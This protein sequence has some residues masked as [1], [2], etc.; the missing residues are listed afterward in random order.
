MGS[1]RAS[2]YDLAIEA[3]SLLTNLR[4]A[5]EVFGGDEDTPERLIFTYNVRMR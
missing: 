5:D 4:N 1:T 3:G 2:G